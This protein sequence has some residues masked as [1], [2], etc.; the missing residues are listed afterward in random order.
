MILVNAKGDACP[1][2]VIKARKALDEA[3]ATGQDAVEVI[4]DNMIAVKN[5]TKLAQS[6]NLEIEFREEGEQEFVVVFDLSGAG[7]AAASEETAP[8]DGKRNI[9]VAIGSDKMGSGADGL[10]HILMKSFIFALSQQENLPQAVILFNSGASLSCEGSPTLADLQNLAAAG[11]EIIT[12]GTCL[13][14]LK[15]TDKLAVGE[16]S[17]MYSIVEKMFSA[18]HLVQ[19]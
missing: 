9:V 8:E 2:P 13:D 16:P 17:N 15:L 18:D 11:V 12:C 6:R 14:Y 7:E 10:G 4:V 5:L 3:L 1:L 19:L